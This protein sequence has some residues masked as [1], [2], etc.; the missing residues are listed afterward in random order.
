MYT[1]LEGKKVERRVDEGVQADVAGSEPLTH[2]PFSN[3]AYSVSSFSTTCLPK[4]HTLVEQWRGMFSLLSYL[5]NEE[6]AECI[7]THSLADVMSGRVNADCDQ[8][9]VETYVVVTP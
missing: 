6:N 4:L 1:N 8:C 9:L 7:S 5:P 3:L 2:R